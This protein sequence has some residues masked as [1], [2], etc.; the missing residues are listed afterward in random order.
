[1][2]I[3]VIDTAMDTAHPVFSG[4]RIET[5]DAL[6]G[7]GAPEAHGTAIA[8]IAAAR[9][10]LEGVAPAADI[11][12]VRA[13][14]SQAGASAK[15]FTFAILKGL[16]WAVMRGARIVNMSFAGPEDPILARAVAA[17]HERGLILVAA[18]GNGG[19]KAK[20]AYPAAYTQVLAVTATDNRDELYKDAN[21]GRYIALAAPGVDIIAAA[22][23]GAYDISSGTSLAAAHVSGIAALMLERDPNLT[24][25]DIRSV[26]TASA[27]K[28]KGLGAQGAGSGVADAAAA[29]AAIKR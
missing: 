22:P 9:S 1:V 6:S 27:Q 7:A 29:L 18:A 5:F 11:I 17:A 28:I 16:D 12:S 20:P 26:L 23:G 13:F 14:S 19:P 24:L 3:A 25:A 10:G 4:A 2:K 8:G 21:R 15:S